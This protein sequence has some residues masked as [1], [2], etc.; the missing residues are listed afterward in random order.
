MPDWIDSPPE[1]VTIFTIVALLMGG[2]VWLIRAQVAQMKEL[3]PNGGSSMRDAVN[4]I[5]RAL[6]EMHAEIRDLRQHDV[7]QQDRLFNSIGKVHS[8]IDEHVR[9]HLLEDKKHG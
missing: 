2:L 9:D 4:R 7:E 1:V 3:K 5:E 8:R 6:M